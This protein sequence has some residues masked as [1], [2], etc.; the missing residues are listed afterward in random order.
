MRCELCGEIAV[1][2]IGDDFLA[3]YSPGR[4]LC[5]TCEAL[6]PKRGTGSFGFLFIPTNDEEEDDG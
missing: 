1:E 6:H 2:T 4:A 3:Q 5:P